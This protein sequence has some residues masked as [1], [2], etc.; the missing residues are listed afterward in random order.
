MTRVCLTSRGCVK[1]EVAVKL[2][3]PAEAV[4][5]EMSRF[6]Q[7][8][9]ADPYHTRITDTAGRRFDALPPRGTRL[10]IGHGVGW[11]W[12]ERVG[13]MLYVR[14]GKGFAF[15]DLSGRGRAVGFPHVYHYTLEPRD[16]RGCVLRL[17]VRGRWSARW[18][19]RGLVMVWL[20]WVM[21]QAGWL[22]RAR[23]VF[24]LHRERRTQRSAGRRPAHAQGESR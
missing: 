18:L 21:F 10:R 23:L 3:A 7:F 24:A 2:A 11:T 16:G 17:R 5:R 19:P 4:W 14:D 12:F 15:S 22:M 9:A 8:I 6:Q 13:T 20:Y 1:A